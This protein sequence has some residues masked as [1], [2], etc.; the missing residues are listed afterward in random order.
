MDLKHI[1]L[2]LTS[3]G[4]RVSI[5]HSYDGPWWDELREAGVHCL[6]HGRWELAERAAIHPRLKTLPR[7]A[8]MGLYGLDLGANQGPAALRYAA[9]IKRNDVTGVFLNNGLGHNITGCLAARLTGVPLYAYFQGNTRKNRLEQHVVPWAERIFAV[10]R[11]TAEENARQG[12]PDANVGVLYPGIDLTREHGDGSPR[13]EDGRVRVGMVGM[14]TPWKGQL[15]FLDAFGIAA[16]QVPHLDAWLFGDAV[17]GHEPYAAAVRAKIEALDLT[18][19]VRIITDRK[20][21]ET[22]Y[23]EVDF[24]THSSISPEPFGRVIIEAMIFARPCIIAGDGGTAEIVRD[25]ETG[26][27]ASPRQPER[28][29]DRIATLATRAD[30]RHAMGAQAR[31]HVLENFTYPE[32]LRPLLDELNLE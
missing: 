19:R 5:A 9:W 10:S 30:H 25:G 24:T 3:R 28:V 11:W 32:V 27:V 15:E 23:P 29:A 18:K 6:R 1:A 20:R 8:R 22:I 7:L 4:V 14:L 31:Q 17:P 13:A 12:I 26:Y 21:P 16:A 2:E